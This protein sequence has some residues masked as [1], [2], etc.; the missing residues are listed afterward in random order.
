MADITNAKMKNAI[1]KKLFNLI[2]FLLIADSISAQQKVSGRVLDEKKQGA[3]FVN[4]LV[5]NAKDSSFVK[6]NVADVEGNYAVSLINPN[7]YF[8]QITAV[9]Y[10]KYYQKI[11]VFDKD[12]ILNDI[13]LSLDNPTL[14]EVE[15]T[16]RK[17]LIERTGD[18]MIMNLEA[19]PIT[20]GLNG[21][22]LMEKVPGV[23]VDRNSETIKIKGKSGVLVMID[24]RKTYLDSDQLAAYLKT[25]KSADIEKIEVITNPSARYDASGTAAIINIITKKGKSLGTNYIVDVSA[26]YSYYDEVGNLPKNGQ[27]FT[28]NSKKEKY[29]LFASVS[30][31]NDKDFNG[32]N[33]IQRIFGEGKSLLETRQ[34]REITTALNDS[35]S[36]KIGL[37]YDFSKK[38]SIGFSLQSALSDNLN[39]RKVTQQNKQSDVFKLIQLDRTKAANNQNYIFNTHWKQTFDTS[40]TILTMDF[41]MIK[42]VNNLDEHFLTTITE[43]KKINFVNNQILF[44]NHSSTYV[45]KADFVKQIMKKTKL[46]MGIK[47]SFG[48]NDQDF[49]DNFRDN[50]V[51]MNSFFRFQENIN[52]AYLMANHEFNEKTSLQV[53]LRGEQTQTKGESKQGE[54]LTEQEYFNLFPTLSLNHRVHKNYTVSCGYSRRIERPE[55]NNFNI[56]KR[57]FFPQQYSQGNPTIL[58]TLENTFNV[59]HTIKDEFSFS[60]DYTSTQQFSTGVYDID[61]TL[62]SGRRLIR[63]SNENVSGKVDWWSFDASLPFNVAKWWNI[64]LNFWNGINVY[65]YQR[66]NAAVEVN[67][68]YGGL[69]LQQ[70]FTLSK[71]LSSELSGYVNSGE[72]WGFQ[73]SKTQGAF[74]IG[75][76]Q[77]LWEKKATLKL[78]IQDP[79]NLNCWRN[80]VQTDN[81]ETAG[82]YR[83]DNRRIRLNFSYNFGNINVKVN[84]RNNGEN[85]GGGKRGKG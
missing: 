39:G 53:G 27:G 59:T 30:R 62:I 74:D 58:P 84:Q 6:G 50:G 57:F 54:T 70:T 81:L 19:S 56:F 33:E 85:G 35:W 34:N 41:D 63:E 29:A 37:D 20:A 36:A 44:P 13:T 76:K 8:I 14:K 69:Y 46:E 55:D 65:D 3:S 40:G 66:E 26:G 38:T 9:G 42:N 43:N 17:P 24:D 47:G 1:M 31:N 80:T 71:T 64:N 75:F 28:V 51:L 4:I 23:T 48:I 83:W 72:T 82:I 79:A 45:L 77:F 60:F 10:L 16:A 52:A 61:S 68:W 73:T 2:L 78:S 25:L 5:L 32:S 21:L 49:N 22:E 67:Q 12:L 18:K 11:E 7:Q 15:V